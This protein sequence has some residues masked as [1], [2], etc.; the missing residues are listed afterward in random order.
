MQVNGLFER[1]ALLYNKSTLST[2]LEFSAKV[3]YVIKR[4]I[5]SN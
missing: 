3:E 5:I 1:V 2:N 4:G